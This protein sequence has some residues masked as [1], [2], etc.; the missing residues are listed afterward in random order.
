MDALGLIDV[1]LITSG[2]MHSVSQFRV[3][4]YGWAEIVEAVSP[5][6][7][8]AEWRQ[9]DDVFADERVPSTLPP[10]QV[11]LVWLFPCD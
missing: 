4:E 11:G 7:Q 3:V 10:C 2:L 1:V 6:G 9:V 5:F 8:Q